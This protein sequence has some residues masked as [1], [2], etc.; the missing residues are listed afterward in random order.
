MRD[1]S[2][3]EFQVNFFA[4]VFRLEVETARLILYTCYGGNFTERPLEYPLFCGSALHGAMG[5]F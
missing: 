4:V 2:E 1:C 3:I 5:G